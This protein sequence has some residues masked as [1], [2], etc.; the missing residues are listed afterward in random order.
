MGALDELRTITAHQASKRPVFS[1]R[2]DAMK[3]RRLLDNDARLTKYT[4]SLHDRINQARA[5]GD[6]REAEASR[7][8]RERMTGN[9][10]AH[11]PEGAFGTQVC[12]WEQDGGEDEQQSNYDCMSGDNYECLPD[13]EY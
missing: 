12:S 13:D 6:I 9:I 11:G 5:A 4:G 10:A 2:E 1:R 7:M 3:K 8:H